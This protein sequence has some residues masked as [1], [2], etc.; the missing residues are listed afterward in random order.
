MYVIENRHDGRKLYAV[1]TDARR[2][3]LWELESRCNMACKYCYDSRTRGAVTD[4]ARVTELVLRLNESDVEYVHIT[5]GEPTLHPHF[6]Q[7]MQ[8]LA[9]KKIYVTTNLVRLPPHLLSVLLHANVSSVAVSL[10]STS[11]AENDFLRGHTADVMRNLRLLLDYRK[12]TGSKTKIRIHS[13]ISKANI[14][15][16]GALLTWAKEIGV[17]EVSCQPISIP[18]SHPYYEA[19]ALTNEHV[20]KIREIL[21]TEGK[22]FHAQYAEAHS[23]LLEYYLSVQDCCTSAGRALCYPYI[24]AGGTVWNCPKKQYEI[25]DSFCDTSDVS[26]V[27]DVT[28]QC[29]C[30]LK[31]HTYSTEL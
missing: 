14:D 26:P 3:V 8:T 12:Q 11:A 29:M 30:C 21:H 15:S 28:P 6:E 24:D 16:L 18:P 9:N 20:D 7:I 31:R 4:E 27:C 5:G 10:D 19:L 2:H 13:V 1:H 23:K 17:D 22:L 25:G